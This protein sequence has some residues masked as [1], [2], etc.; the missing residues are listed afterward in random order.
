MRSQHAHVAL[1]LALCNMPEKTWHEHC[2]MAT[3]KLKGIGHNH[4]S[5]A[6]TGSDW[7]CDL[8]VEITFFQ[9]LMIELKIDCLLS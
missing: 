8:R 2:Q 5:N 6:K 4:F 1:C 3:A 9:I 7:H